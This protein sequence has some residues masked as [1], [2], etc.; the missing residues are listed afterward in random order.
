MDRD[1]SRSRSQVSL[2]RAE[3]IDF[4][5]V[6]L[7]F[8]D[9]RQLA[10]NPHLNVEEK[11]AFPVSY[12]RGYEDAIFKD[13][14]R[15]L[16]PLCDLDRVVVDIGCGVGGLTERIVAA[17]LERRH[18]LI[19]VDSEEMLA[20]AP[21]GIGVKQVP[22][23]YPINAEAVHAATKG[24]ADAVICYSVL[25]YAFLD[26]NLY[27]FVDA[28]ID[29]LRPGGMALLGDI[30]NVSK[31]RRF[32][33]SAAGIAFHKAFTGA[34]EPP[35]VQ[36]FQVAHDTIDDAVLWGLV[37]RAQAAGCNAYVLPQGRDLPMSN[38]RDDILIQKP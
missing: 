38:R 9:F 28:I 32:F 33:S 21:S 35:E 11:I 20:G 29:L 37:A 15:K 17:C 31:R 34:D 27:R 6:K 22:G 26:T 18:R 24:G 3:H 1:S 7:G 23:M 30:P 10:Q 8:E 4:S 12:R 25:H 14:C 19:L 2:A 13:I 16:E 5:R 36:H